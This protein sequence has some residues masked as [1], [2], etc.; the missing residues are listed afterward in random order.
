MWAGWIEIWSY[1]KKFWTEALS[2]WFR[3]I[4]HHFKTIVITELVA[5]Y[6][7]WRFLG[8]ELSLWPILGYI[9]VLLLPLVG[10][11]IW[12]LLKTSPKI[13]QQSQTVISGLR[14]E[15]ADAELERQAPIIILEYEGT[16]IL[17]GKDR[18]IV[19]RNDG[20][21]TVVGAQFDEIREE[22]EDGIR[23][24]SFGPPVSQIQEGHRVEVRGRC[25][26]KAGE[27]IHSLSKTSFK[28]FLQS[29]LDNT[30]TAEVDLVLRYR[31][32]DYNPW[33]IKHTVIYHPYPSSSE[34]SV[35]VEYHGPP[36]LDIDP[37]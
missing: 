24:V 27:V 12:H 4:L 32:T 23:I 30:W 6:A 29:K 31:D 13:D 9:G 14:T 8:Q 22:I 10:I 15:L 20:P 19:L 3:A 26:K 25:S 37:S 34:G 1:E 17:K 7:S 36:E 16:A 2:G 35:R 33:R 5:L 11:L 18:P 21:G 28:Q